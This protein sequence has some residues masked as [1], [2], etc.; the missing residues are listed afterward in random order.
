MGY[1]YYISTNVRES[2]CTSKRSAPDSRASRH[3]PPAMAAA[4]TA[5]LGPRKLRPHGVI[6]FS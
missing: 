6:P 3:A 1:Y 5:S 4:A 2:Q